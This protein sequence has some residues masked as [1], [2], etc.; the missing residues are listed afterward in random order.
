M[1]NTKETKAEA[2]ATAE[3]E[4]VEQE[5]LAKQVKEPKA[6]SRRRRINT[7]TEGEEFLPLRSAGSQV[8]AVS[9]AGVRCGGRQREGRATGRYGGAR[10]GELR[11]E[12]PR[13]AGTGE[14][15]P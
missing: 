12:H 6:N 7:T 3:Q 15:P 10:T 2:K 8:A 11:Q 9:T 13:R 5:F 14:P 4:A 1:S